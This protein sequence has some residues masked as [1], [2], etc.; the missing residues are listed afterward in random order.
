[1]AAMN[2]EKTFGWV[3]RAL[4]WSTAL[5]VLSTLP[6]GLWIAR[7]EP[8]LAAIRYFGWH[9]TLGVTVL[10]LIVLRIVW[11]RVTPPPAPMPSGAKW[12][13]RAARAA[14]K[15]FY[16]LL[17]AMPLSGWIASSATGIDTVVFGGFTLPRIA[18]VSETWETAGFLIH[19]IIGWG[20]IVLVGLHVAGALYHSAVMKDGTLTRML[21]GDAGTS[22]VPR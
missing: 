19:G 20:L 8:S 12:Q 9:K 11:H 1:M 13:D 5:V 2:G 17:I 22:S 4:H 3:T 10:A 21:R 16:V 18:P 6:L 14:H 15:A 7:M